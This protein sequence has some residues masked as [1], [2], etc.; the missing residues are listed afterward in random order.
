MASMTTNSA[1]IIKL[2]ASGKPTASKRIPASVGP[3]NAPKPKEDVHRPGNYIQI[4]SIKI[5]MIQETMMGFCCHLRWDR[6]SQCFLVIQKQS[7]VVGLRQ[8]QKHFEH[9][10]QGLPSS[11]GWKMDISWHISISLFLPWRTNAPIV[12]PRDFWKGRKGMGPIIK[13]LVRVRMA[14]HNITALACFWSQA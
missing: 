1:V 11:N 12:R 3:T 7:L 4:N 5:K 8:T 6:M 14:P 9:P 13:K 2:V 10:N